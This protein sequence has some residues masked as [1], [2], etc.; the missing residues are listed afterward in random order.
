MVVHHL[1]LQDHR[2]YE[3]HDIV[4]TLHLT[5][6]LLLINHFEPN[7]F[8]NTHLFN[9]AFVCVQ[10]Y[11]SIQWFLFKWWNA[12]QEQ[13]LKTVL[14]RIRE[15]MSKRSFCKQ[16]TLYGFVSWKVTANG[17]IF[18]IFPSLLCCSGIVTECYSSS[19]MQWSS[20][21]PAL[22]RLHHQPLIRTE[23]N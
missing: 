19:Y 4:Q 22:P 17:W 14:G 20:K 13:E 7:C 11:R 15:I 12:L 10:L 18:G 16:Q 8:K 5:N 9:L 3:F 1:K 23:G 2:Q 6:L 21:L